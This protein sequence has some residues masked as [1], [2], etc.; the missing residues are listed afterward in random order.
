MAWGDVLLQHL[1]RA[2]DQFWS[3][4]VYHNLDHFSLDFVVRMTLDADHQGP[5][6]VLHR[7]SNR[8][9]NILK[10]RRGGQRH[11]VSDDG[12]RV[13]VHTSISTQ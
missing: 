2:I 7:R 12:S 5:V 11:A 4:G 1:D 6:V 8:F 3:P 9:D 13:R 10:R